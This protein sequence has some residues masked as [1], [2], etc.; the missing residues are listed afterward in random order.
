MAWL[1]LQ[2]KEVSL[3]TVWR[4]NWRKK[5]LVKNYNSTGN[6]IQSPDVRQ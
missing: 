4:T 2:A 6:K 1:N 3:A 5:G